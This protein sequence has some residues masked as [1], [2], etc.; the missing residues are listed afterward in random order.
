MKSFVISIILVLAVTSRSFSAGVKDM[1]VISI[2][3]PKMETPRVLVPETLSE[4]KIDEF[5]TGNDLTRNYGSFYVAIGELLYL[6]GRITDAFGV[7]VTN[8]VVKIWQTNSAGKNQ[9]VFKDG[10]VWIDDEFKVSGMAKTDNS[11]YYGFKTIFPGFERK[12]RAPH[13]NVI[14]TH[15]D[16]EE[17]RTEVYFQN[18]PMNEIDPIYLS[19]TPEERNLLTAKVKNINSQDAKGGKIATFNIVINGIH[20]YKKY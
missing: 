17:I 16:Y 20:A 5:F 8:A 14:I 3:S 2:F 18:H 11:G 1:E 12:D 19:Y 10:S 6:K 15:R 4:P 9:N 13:I 7:P